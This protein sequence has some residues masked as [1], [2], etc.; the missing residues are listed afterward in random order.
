LADTKIHLLGAFQ[1]LKLA[2]NAISSLILDSEESDIAET[3]VVKKA[4]TI[5]ISSSTPHST[6]GQRS[7]PRFIEGR[8]WQLHWR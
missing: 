8:I 4:C 6:I 7:M 3:L 2:R 1:N 5:S